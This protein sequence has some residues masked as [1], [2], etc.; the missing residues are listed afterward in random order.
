[1]CTGECDDT[2]AWWTAWLIDGRGAFAAGHERHFTRARPAAHPM[3]VAGQHRIVWAPATARRSI[4]ATT[5]SIITSQPLSRVRDTLK[6]SLRSTSNFTTVS[7]CV[8]LT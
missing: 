8:E 1:M 2:R 7:I 3:F 5:R 4:S 6:I